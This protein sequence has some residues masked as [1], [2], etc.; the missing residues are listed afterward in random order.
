[1]GA[2]A[3]VAAACE[4]KRYAMCVPGG[5]AEPDSW[6]VA[7]VT[8]CGD[9]TR[10]STTFPYPKGFHGVKTETMEYDHAG[11]LSDS[12]LLSCPL[13]R[14]L[15]CPSFAE[16]LPAYEIG[17][18]AYES[19][20]RGEPAACREVEEALGRSGSMSAAWPGGGTIGCDGNDAPAPTVPGRDDGLEHEL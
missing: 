15:S 11:R 9:A 14:P 1:M 7:S 12:A 20:A 6:W 13:S 17:A 3:E 10:V 5:G 19:L 2:G 18:A 4:A 8:R 16:A